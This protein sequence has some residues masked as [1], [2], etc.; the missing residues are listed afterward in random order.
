VKSMGKTP[1]MLPGYDSDY[2]GSHAAF[3]VRVGDIRYWKNVPSPPV[4]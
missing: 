1:K 2:R 4:I 3:V